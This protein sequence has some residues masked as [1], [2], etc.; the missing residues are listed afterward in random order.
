M[1]TGKFPKQ[2]SITKDNN[3]TAP[4]IQM[5]LGN[6]NLLCVVSCSIIGDKGS[7]QFEASY[8]LF[9]GSALCSH[10]VVQEVGISKADSVFK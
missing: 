2:V 8:S 10:G 6:V 1:P 7:A 4:K 5:I 9:Y 3:T